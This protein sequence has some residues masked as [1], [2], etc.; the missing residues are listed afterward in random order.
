MNKSDCCNA[1]RLKENDLLLKAIDEIVQGDFYHDMDF[2]L[3]M[4]EEFTQEEAKQ[5][6]KGL[7]KIYQLAHSRHCESCRKRILIEI[8]QED[9]NQ[10]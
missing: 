10:E 1:G 5:C 3:A 4:E 9:T 7:M 2:K 8:I 6:V